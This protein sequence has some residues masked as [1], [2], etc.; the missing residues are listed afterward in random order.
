[1]GGDHR[2]SRNPERGPPYVWTKTVDQILISIVGNYCTKI[3]D[4]GH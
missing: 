3:N 4:S 1:M 2:S